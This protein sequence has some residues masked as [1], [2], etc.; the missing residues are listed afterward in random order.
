MPI[1][2]VDQA[3]PGMVLSN[4]VTDR[5]GRLLIPAGLALSEKHVNA[6]KMWGI[7]SLDIE[8]DEE[9]E[10]VVNVSPEALEAAR[11]E[12]MP[13]YRHTDLDHPFVHKLFEHKAQHRAREIASAPP[14]E[15]VP[16]DSPAAAPVATEP[17][18]GTPVGANS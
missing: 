7:V 14:A 9:V 5:R 12:L 15:A 17:L 6:L 16:A 11:A 4:P 10:V 13:L 1:V 2:S 3:T 18:A 8:G